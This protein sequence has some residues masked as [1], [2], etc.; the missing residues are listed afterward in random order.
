MTTDIDAKVMASIDEAMKGDKKPYFQSAIYYLENGK[1]LNKAMEWMN[2]ADAADGGK[3]PWIKLWKG[4][5]QLKMGDKKGAAE[6]AA[7]GIKIATEIKNPEY[8]RLNAALLADA[9]K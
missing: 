2:A 8:I 1:D 4:R 3:G 7:A 5:V 9:K 6:S